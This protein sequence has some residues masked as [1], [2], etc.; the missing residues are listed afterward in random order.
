MLRI[1]LIIIIIIWVGDT[2]A[3]SHFTKCNTNS[4]VRALS[5]M[6]FDRARTTMIASIIQFVVLCTLHVQ[7][8]CFGIKLKYNDLA[9]EL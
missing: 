1:G 6:R 2:A 8:N 4:K 5:R 9:I 3:V 7:V